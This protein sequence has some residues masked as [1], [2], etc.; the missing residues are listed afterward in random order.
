MSWSP[1]QYLRF[2]APRLRPAAD[3]LAAVPL[4]APRAVVDLGCGAGN[5]TRLIG[6]RWLEAR[7]TGVDDSA[8]M[9]A[10]AAQEFPRARW[11]QCGIADWRAGEPVDLIYS[12]AALQWLG[13]HERL[14]P[15]LLAQLAPGGVLAVQMP[16]NFEA[17]SHREIANTVRSGPWRARLAPLLVPSPVAAPGVYYEILAPLAAR[18]DIWETE[19][20]QVLEGEDPV[21]EWTKGTWLRQFLD[22]LADDA[23]R[24]AFEANYAARLRL[25][26]PRRSDGRTL[27]PFR[28]LFLVA[29]AP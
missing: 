29:A 26:Y 28:R 14:F 6:E 24:A 5:V 11:Q 27:F 22:A 17:P 8:A 13:D 15:S 9:L 18:L 23:E 16:R 2:A 10:K 7:I 3:L 4:T 1:D 21:K 25:A 20:L 12:N 19:Y